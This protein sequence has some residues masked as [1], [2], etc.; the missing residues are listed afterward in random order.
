MLSFH[1]KGPGDARGA[2][3]VAVMPALLAR[4]R[5]SPAAAQRFAALPALTLPGGL[6]VV[7]ARSFAARGRGLAR[8]DAL[9]PDV[10]LWIAPCRSVHT[11]GMRFA[12]DLVWLDRQDAVLAVDAGVSPRR[13]RTRLGAR[14]VV[15]VVAGRGEAFATAWPARARAGGG[16]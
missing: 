16:P 5:R 6:T 9:P 13:Q 14:S 1:D 7:E 2:G 3:T 15:E 4:R 8:L 12:L 11:F 10:G